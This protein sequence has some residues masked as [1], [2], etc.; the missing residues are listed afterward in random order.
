MR[1][2]GVVA[3]SV[4]LAALLAA[5]FFPVAVRGCERTDGGGGACLANL[6][7]LCIAVRMYALDSGGVLPDADRWVDQL[8]PRY[9]DNEAALKCSEDR[10]QARCSYGMN[11]ALSGRK[12]DETGE[13]SRV[14]LLY[15]TAHPGE[16][17]SGGPEDAASPPRHGRLNWYVLLDGSGRKLEEAPS[18]EVE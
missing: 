8:V 7:Q 6:H 17:P 2:W 4:G 9:I 10:T 1:T 18:F 14:V 13:D 12:L 3:A 11:R 16:N 15:E 5:F